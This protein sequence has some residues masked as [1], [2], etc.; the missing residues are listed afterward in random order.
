VTT[1]VTVAFAVPLGLL[2]AAFV[3]SSAVTDADRAAAAVATV[4]VVTADPGAIGKAVRSGALGRS[5]HVAVLLPSGAVAG[6]HNL[7]ADA[8][9]VARARQASGPVSADTP[10]GLLRLLGAATAGGGV[11]VVEVFVPDDRMRRGVLPAYGVL[12]AIALGLLLACAFLADRL[13]AGAVR[14]TSELADA[15]T[16]LGDGDPAVRVQPAGP[17]EV[18]KAGVA[19]NRLAER[20]LALLAAERELSADLSHRLRTPLT[21]LRLNAEALPAGEHRNKIMAAADALDDEIGTIMEQAQHP[22]VSPSPAECDLV[23]AVADRLTFWS[24][25]ARDQDRAAG[26]NGVQGA[27]QVPVSRAD[28]VSALDAVLG[29]VFQHT[30]PG[31]GFRVVLDRDEGAARVTVDDEGAGI[32]EPAQALR[33]G[34]SGGDSTGLG[35]DIA[36]RVTRASGGDVTIATSPLGGV[37]VVL[38]FG[39]VTSTTPRQRS[40]RRF[41]AHRL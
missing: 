36:R 21:R 25:L 30:P 28:A 16:R 41:R 18:L 33:R 40:R 22:L 7:R 37:R 13:A 19:F 15:A 6:G 29:N 32:A 11:S 2:I 27:V 31:V 14:A 4:L 26:S 10:G 20:F 24:E 38:T 12:A 39:R 35:L 17:P 8:A 23:E 34:V 1:L 3:R 5:G 9:A